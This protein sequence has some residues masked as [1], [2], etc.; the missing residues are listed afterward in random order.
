MKKPFRFLTAFFL[1]AFAYTT[2]NAQ[3]KSA[4]NQ[5]IDCHKYRTYSFGGWDKSGSQELN[6]LDKG[7]FLAAFK[8]EF[9]ERNMTLVPD[10]ADVVFTLLFVVD[11]ATITHV[12]DNINKPQNL[13]SDKTGLGIVN[14][15]YQQYYEVGSV[16]VDFFDGETKE[17]V[18]QAAMLEPLTKKEKK[19]E[20]NIAK[21]AKALMKKY[22]VE[23]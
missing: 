6:D 4:Y 21:A 20:K 3:V 10:S 19:H 9:A 7:R 22:P 13:Y 2:V 23:A 1:L 14:V 17:Q 8:E 15:L 5:T 16:S 18:G 12:D 11:V